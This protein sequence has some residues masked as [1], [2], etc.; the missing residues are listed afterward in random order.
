MSV[1]ACRSGVPNRRVFL[2]RDILRL[3]RFGNRHLGN[4]L[5]LQH[6]SRGNHKRHNTFSRYSN[7]LGT[8]TPVEIMQRLC[9]QRPASAAVFA[10]TS[11]PQSLGFYRLKFRLSSGMA[12]AGQKNEFSVALL[13][14]D[15][16]SAFRNLDGCPH[17]VA[18]RLDRLI[19]ILCVA[20]SHGCHDRNL[21]FAAARNDELVA[22][23]ETLDR[24]I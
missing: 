12:V 21:A 24:Q 19:N 8:S 20:A 1:K 3:L 5:K 9:T 23:P 18:V 16:R 22:P 15:P 6:L 7:R 10:A 11:A 4:P 13:S 14:S 2:W 17:C